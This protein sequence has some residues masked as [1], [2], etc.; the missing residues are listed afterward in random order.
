[1]FR[2]YTL[3]RQPRHIVF[4]IIILFFCWVSAVRAF[5]LVYGISC[6]IFKCMTHNFA[7]LE[8]IVYFFGASSKVLCTTCGDDDDE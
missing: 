6:Q 1:M 7:C 3:Y 5:F 4:I 2:M 8:Y